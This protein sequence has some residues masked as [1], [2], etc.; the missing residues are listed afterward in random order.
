MDDLGFNKIAGAVLATALGMMILT[1]LPGVLI[2]SSDTSVIAYKVGP[3]DTGTEEVELELPFPQADWVAAM[4]AAKG[5]RVF[6]KCVSC[7]NVEEGG[8]NGT[9]PGL[10]GVVGAQKAVHPG[11]EFSA[12]LAGMDGQWGY[13]ELDGFLERPSAYV[14]GTKMNFI[15]L[16]KAEDRAAV[17][18]YLRVASSNPLPRPEPAA[19]IVE[20][21]VEMEATAANEGGVVETERSMEQPTVDPSEPDGDQ[22]A[23]EPGLEE[24]VDDDILVE[25]NEEPTEE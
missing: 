22:I 1:K 8:A 6:K 2:G 17:I 14:S 12:A 13:E 25:E 11:Y 3:I 15:G 20:E 9:G 21:P 19:V 10:W 18:E 23:E 16:K 4:D 5:A 7:H 24:L